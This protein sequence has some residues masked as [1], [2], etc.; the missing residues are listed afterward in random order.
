MIYE[1]LLKGRENAIPG[2]QLSKS[3]DMD[4]RTLTK[5]IERERQAGLPI[6]AV[7]TGADKGYFLASDA[8]DLDQYCRSLDRRLKNIQKTRIAIGDTLDKMS[9]QEQ[10]EGW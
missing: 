3:L 2:R 6:C 5:Q 9:E 8:G 10:A 1:I 4:I 7:T